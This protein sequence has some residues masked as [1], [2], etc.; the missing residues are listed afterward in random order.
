MNNEPG[1][2]EIFYF[3]RDSLAFPGIIN[4]NFNL[5]IS[6]RKGTF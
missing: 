5:C 3:L 2:N 1:F 6:I 4:Q